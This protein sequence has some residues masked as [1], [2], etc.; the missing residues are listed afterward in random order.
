MVKKIFPLLLAVVL[1]GAGCTTSTSVDDHISSDG[2]AV[3]PGSSV[4]HNEDVGY[5]IS[6]P[7]GWHVGRNGS[8]DTSVLDLRYFQPSS[9]KFGPTVYVTVYGERGAEYDQN[10]LRS[11][12]VVGELGSNRYYVIYE[13]DEENEIS[14]VEYRLIANSPIRSSVQ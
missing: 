14:E 13:E 1:V 8:P 10:A 3:E 2:V 12:A 9:S 11:G 6:Y 4:F 5:T 7:G